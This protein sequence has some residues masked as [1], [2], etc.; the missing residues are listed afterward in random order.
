MHTSAWPVA[1]VILLVLVA[2][3]AT[4]M[5]SDSL[6]IS[7]QQDGRADIHFA[8][9]L[10]WLEYIA[11]Y[12][13]LVDP[14]AELKKALESNFGK[15]VT[16]LSVNSNSVHLTVD[17]FARVSSSNGNITARTPGLSFAEG[18]KIL[19]SYWFAPLV[20][21]DLSPSVTTIRFPDGY[22]ETFSDRI[23]IPPL[24]HTWKA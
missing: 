17:S 18:E 8:Y 12:L 15:P 11:V 20:R 22:V 6:D 16:V 13:R 10:D 7:I 24:V 23:G 3:P 4:A 1:I 9:H 19:K 2:T 5:T 21:V 14:A